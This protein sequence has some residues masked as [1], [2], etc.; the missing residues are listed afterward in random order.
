MAIVRLQERSKKLY[1]AYMEKYVKE[2]KEDSLENDD[3]ERDMNQSSN[4]WFGSNGSTGETRS[5]STRWCGSVFDPVSFQLVKIPNSAYAQNIKQ[6]VIDSWLQ[7]SN[8]ELEVP[9]LGV[10]SYHE[11]ISSLCDD[12]NRYASLPRS[13]AGFILGAAR[14]PLGAIVHGQVLSTGE[15]IQLIPSIRRNTKIWVCIRTCLRLLRSRLMEEHASCCNIMEN[16]QLERAAE[17]KWQRLRHKLIL[18]EQCLRARGVT[19]TI[20]FEMVSIVLD[21]CVQ[22]WQ[23]RDHLLSKI[24][25][26]LKTI[27]SGKHISQITSNNAVEVNHERIAW[28]PH[29]FEKALKRKVSQMLES[30]GINF[31]VRTDPV[32]LRCQHDDTVSLRPDIVIEDSSNGTN[33]MIKGCI[34]AKLYKHLN[35]EYTFTFGVKMDVYLSACEQR[36]GFAN[37]RL[38]GVTFVGLH[39]ESDHVDGME[40][41]RQDHLICVVHLYQRS[42]GDVEDAL[43]EQIRKSLIFLGLLE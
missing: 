11:L 24:L 16:G 25:G 43:Q 35:R 38:K 1:E 42:L 22:R 6:E 41:E 13:K 17:D 21:S 29:L 15:N 2:Q 9:V 37:L 4:I 20:S 23:H 32:S 19:R 10:A 34:D 27:F 3:L 33:R 26:T 8:I 28:V 40:L 36:N 14:Y 30:E 5:I 12:I 18:T 39:G 31:A 7:Q